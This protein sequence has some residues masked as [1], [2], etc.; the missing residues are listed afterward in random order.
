MGPPPSNL[1]GI[2]SLLWTTFTSFTLHVESGWEHVALVFALGKCTTRGGRLVMP[3]AL[4]IHHAAA[5]GFHPSRLLEEL[6]DVV[7]EPD[8]VN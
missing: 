5:D 8:W 3:V 1:V 4:Q 7:G 6:A 2:S